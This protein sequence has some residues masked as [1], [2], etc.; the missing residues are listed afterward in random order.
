MITREKGGNKGFDFDYN[1]ILN[2]P[3]EDEI[4]NPKDAKEALIDAFKEAVKGT[5]YSTPENSKTAITIKVKDKKHSIILHSCDFAVV[6]K[7]KNSGDTFYKFIRFN[8]SNNS[9]S[10][11]IRNLSKNVD[12]KLK[13]LKQNIDDY[14]LIIKEEYLKVK[15]SNDD[16]DKHSFQLFYESV[17]NVFNSFYNQ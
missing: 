13:W 8:K 12:D 15:N 17:N 1:L 2:N 5:L 10:W 6:Y 9:Y 14:W 16:L 3:S 11:E 7:L 4:W